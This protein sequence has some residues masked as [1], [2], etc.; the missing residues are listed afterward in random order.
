MRQNSYSGDKRK[1][2]PEAKT[3]NVLE[4]NQTKYMKP[5][6]VFRAKISLNTV[7][8]ISINTHQ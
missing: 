3:K 7:S 2:E 4:G 6:R 5:K 8:S 1:T